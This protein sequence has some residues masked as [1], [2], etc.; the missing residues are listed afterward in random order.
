MFTTVLLQ[1]G[2]EDQ[3][4][5]RVF[6]AELALLTLTMALSNYATGEMLDRFAMSPRVIAIA[7]GALFVIPGVVW[8]L[9]QRWWDREKKIR[10][11]QE[12]TS[13][14]ARML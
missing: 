11:S 13:E 10:N 1:R 14:V 7:M 8:F 9:T 4:R 3:F 6:A 12:E 5:G 2:D